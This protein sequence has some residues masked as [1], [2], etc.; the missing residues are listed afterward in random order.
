MEIN[1]ERTA[2]ERVSTTSSR[3]SR[4]VGP[5][6]IVDLVF[7]SFRLFDGED[8]TYF[9]EYVIENFN[10]YLSY[11][12]FSL[13]VK[14]FYLL[15]IYVNS[16]MDDTGLEGEVAIMTRVRNEYSARRMENRKNLVT[17]LTNSHLGA[18]PAEIEPER[19]ESSI[20]LLDSI[21]E[22]QELWHSKNVT[23]TSK[24]DG[25]LEIKKSGKEEKPDLSNTNHTS[26]E[27]PLY[28]NKSG[29]ASSETNKSYTNNTRY[30]SLDN[31]SSGGNSSFTPSTSSFNSFN[32]STRPG[33]SNI[34]GNSA[35][36][37]DLSP[38]RGSAPIR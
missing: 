37:L 38:F 19:T 23:I 11:F 16:D 31:S 30:S 24:K 13:K 4:P 8:L 3:P 27:I 28:P 5:S 6:E 20:N 17:S 1:N 12:I 15:V 18:L 26:K 7:P 14:N 33:F 35:P 29:G 32:P 34:L 10:S 36:A 21:L 2:N 9:S 22:S 25:T